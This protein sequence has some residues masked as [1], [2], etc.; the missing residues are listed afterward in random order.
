M[1]DA[2]WKKKINLKNLSFPFFMAA[3]MDGITDS[4]MRR[5]IR[6]FSKEELLFTEMR[7]ISCVANERSERSLK[8]NQIEEPLAFQVSAN[9]T[10]FIDKAVSKIC[11][12]NFV[13]LNMNAACPAKGI[14]KSGSGS[15]LMANLDRLKEI[16]ILLKTELKDKIPLTIKIRA[17]FKNT[18]ALDVSLLSQDCGVEMI[19]IHPRLQTGRFSSEL[20]FDLVKEIK[21]KVKIPVVFSGNVTNAKRAQ[22]TYEKTGVDGLMIGRPLWG[23]PWKMKEIIFELEGEK[24]CVSSEEA[25][26]C[27]IEHLDLNMEFYGDRGF[28]AFKKHAPQYIKN[29]PD[30]ARIR[31]E[32]VTSQGYEEMRERLVKLNV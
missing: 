28:S 20:D 22:M 19:I 5:M 1:S 9:T 24:F 15:A 30:A 14:V 18:N 7:H 2:F 11:N 6:K 13:M 26:K 25:I 16:L 17:G 10:E 8:Y 31:K 23:V 3:P 32:L 27:A 4:P 29:I 12:K 21:N